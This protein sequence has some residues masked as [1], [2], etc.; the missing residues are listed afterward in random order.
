MRHSSDIF[1]QRNWQQLLPI[2]GAFPKLSAWTQVLIGTTFSNLS[3]A[4]VK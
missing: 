1:R 2:P 4:T 3:I